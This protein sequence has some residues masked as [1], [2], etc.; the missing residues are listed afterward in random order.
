ML[1]CSC[2]LTQKGFIS[3]EICHNESNMSTYHHSKTAWMPLWLILIP[4]VKKFCQSAIDS[5]LALLL[6]RR[7]G[8]WAVSH[9]SHHLFREVSHPISR[10]FKRNKTCRD[11][12]GDPWAQ[13]AS[14]DEGS[15]HRA[16][17]LITSSW[18]VVSGNNIV[19]LILHIFVA[20]N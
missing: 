3:S 8:G 20:A 9:T 11:M 7:I 2:C 16:W 5:L 13:L 12:Y 19:Y 14:L 18:V 1:M 6:C 10:G 17:A 4:H 15:L